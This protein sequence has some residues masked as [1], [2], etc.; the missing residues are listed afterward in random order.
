MDKLLSVRVRKWFGDAWRIG[1][2]MVHAMQC[3]AARYVVEVLV[4]WKEDDNKRADG[5]V[6]SYEK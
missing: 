1:E 2:S 4:E 3:A 5:E 6:M